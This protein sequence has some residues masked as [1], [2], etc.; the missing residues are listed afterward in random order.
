MAVNL[1]PTRTNVQRILSTNPN[2][3]DVFATTNRPITSIPNTQSLLNKVSLGSDV[4]II[5][6]WLRDTYAHVQSGPIYN[7]QGPLGENLTSGK[8]AKDSLSKGIEESNIFLSGADVFSYLNTRI[9]KQLC[10][11]T[12]T[13]VIRSLRDLY[14]D[15]RHSL[16]SDVLTELEIAM[17]EPLPTFKNMF[18]YKSMQN[19]SES[20]KLPLY[21]LF[22][23]ITP[24]SVLHIPV[25]YFIEAL[26]AKVPIQIVLEN[27]NIII[28]LDYEQYDFWDI[29]SESMVDYI[30][31]KSRCK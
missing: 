1:F 9:N 4:V 22:G 2:T 29:I 16:P 3:Q 24:F 26:N 30:D 18:E 23:T 5:P 12:V 6:I 25:S 8:E 11:Q 10:N 19:L 15:N 13:I 27:T 17:K 20:I 28:Q 7:L 31:I 21:Q 14:W